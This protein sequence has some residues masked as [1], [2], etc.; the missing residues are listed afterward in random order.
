L[1]WFLGEQ[2]SDY[3]LV[4]MGGHHHASRWYFDA[5]INLARQYR[6][7]RVMGY[8]SHG[9]EF[10]RLLG[11][12]KFLVH[13][14]GLTGNTPDEVE[15]FGIVAIEA[16]ASGCMPIVHDSGGCRNIPGVRVWRRWDNI[17]PL[18]SIPYVPERLREQTYL[19]SFD[20]MVDSVGR[21]LKEI[22]L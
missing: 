20:R 7:V 13:A 14:Q 19:Y 12:A 17:V 5:T 6:N 15:H 1:D 22:G 8:V 21:M 2:L 4:F 9:D 11:E 10:Y 18:M 16:L 3:E